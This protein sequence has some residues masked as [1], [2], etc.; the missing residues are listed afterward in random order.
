MF[1][2]CS[3]HLLCHFFYWVCESLL[4]TQFL[5]SIQF[6]SLSMSQRPSPKTAGNYGIHTILTPPLP[7]PTHIPSTFTLIIQLFFTCLPSPQS[8][9]PSCSLLTSTSSSL[10]LNCLNEWLQNCHWLSLKQWGIHSGLFQLHFSHLQELPLIIF[11][12]IAH[13]PACSILLAMLDHS[14]SK[15]CFTINHNN[16]LSNQLHLHLCWCKKK[17]K[18]K[19]ISTVIGLCTI[20][21]GL[22]W[23]TVVCSQ[24]HLNHDQSH[25]LEGIET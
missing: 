21:R 8:L 1:H 16:F 5:S 17:K 11:I 7:K 14:L 25:R 12:H 23:A 24:D 10:L 3:L 19:N 6:R 18:V 4:V 20:V 13:N 9:S 2:G 15:N 22:F